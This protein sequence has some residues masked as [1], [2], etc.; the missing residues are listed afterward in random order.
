M[1]FI[2]VPKGQPLLVHKGKL[3]DNSPCIC[4][5][6]S[7]PFSFGSILKG[8][9]IILKYCSIL[10]WRLISNRVEQWLVRK[11]TNTFSTELDVI[12]I[13]W[14]LRLRS[15]IGFNIYR[16]HLWS[17]FYKEWGGEFFFKIEMSSK[18][19]RR[20][21]R[22]KIFTICLSLTIVRWKNKWIIATVRW[23]FI[24]VFYFILF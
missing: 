20:I 10:R 13:S 11:E 3:F 18:D 9:R 4:T 19:E 15:V 12:D 17:Y 6:F 23:I 5:L 8:G 21:C 14:S 22:G 1:S 7:N 16:N 24:K 2:V